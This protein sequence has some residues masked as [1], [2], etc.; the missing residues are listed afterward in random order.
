MCGSTTHLETHRERLEMIELAEVEALRGKASTDER[1]FL[2]KK[3][4]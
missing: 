3:L 4:Y 1:K 2:E